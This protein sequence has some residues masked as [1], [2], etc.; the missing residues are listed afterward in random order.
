MSTRLLSDEWR[1][2]VNKAYVRYWL[3]KK[4]NGAL[5]KITDRKKQT[6]AWKRNYKR[7]CST[8][9]LLNEELAKIKEPEF[10]NAASEIVKPL[11]GEPWPWRFEGK[12]G[13]GYLTNPEACPV[14]RTL[15]FLKFGVTFRELVCELELG[16]KAFDKWKKV[17]AAY[18]KIRW[19]DGSLD[20]LKMKFNSTH[21]Q[22]IAQGLDFGLKG[23]NEWELA[24][25]LDEI[26]PCSQ[27]HS[28]HSLK[29][30]RA[31]IIK[32]CRSFKVRNMRSTTVGA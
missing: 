31:Q 27:K 13:R 4:A 14:F 23:L 15:V 17:H 26:C 22:I 25:C 20:T 18:H 32:A 11:D 1:A 9:R 19:K 6:A 24:H 8:T 2:R 21:F 29:K 28:H 16:P 7:L 12:P 10:A 5:V 3:A 30:L